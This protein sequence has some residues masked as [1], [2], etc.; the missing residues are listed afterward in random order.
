MELT[1]NFTVLLNFQF[2]SG[3]EDERQLESLD[4]E[5]YLFPEILCMHVSRN[6]T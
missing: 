1:F 5:N 4:S 3:F 2:A 6:L